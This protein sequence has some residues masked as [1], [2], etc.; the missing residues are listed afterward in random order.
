MTVLAGDA[1][2]V[3]CAPTPVFDA[4]RMDFLADLSR[5]LLTHPRARTLADVVSFAYWCRRA[6]LAQ[7]AATRRNADRGFD[8]A[9]RLGLGLSFHVC[10]SNVPVN[11]AFSLAFGLLAGNTCVLRLPSKETETAQLLIETISACLARERHA[12]L[13]SAMLLVR[14]D[15]DDAIT[16]FWMAQAD[17]RIVWGGDATVAHMRSL[18]GRPRSR[19]VAFSDRYS[20]CAIDPRAVLELDH[21]GLLDLCARLYNDLYLMDQAA[22]SSP[23]LIAWI[24]AADD[25]AAAQARLWPALAGHARARYA[26]RPVQVMDKFVD[27]CRHALGNP[28]VA[29]VACHDN[30]LYRVA[31]TGLAADQDTCRGYFGTIHEVTLDTLDPLAPIVNERYQTLTYFGMEPAQLREFVTAQRLRGVDRVVP[32]GRALDMNIVWDGYDL[33]AS[34]SRV[35]DVR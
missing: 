35:I 1:Q 27:A 32:V 6:N 11:F 5:A 7:L 20:L 24:G 29:S 15:H 14:Y 25:A 8:G 16:G 21:G 18:P 10:P 17:A 12:P 23:Q 2:S 19:E 26:M 22:C 3:S 34:L 9:V 33:V 4:P 31:L 30:V 28:R 13:A